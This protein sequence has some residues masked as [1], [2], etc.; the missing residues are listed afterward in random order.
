MMTG[1]AEGGALSTFYYPILTVAAGI[2]SWYYQSEASRPLRRWSSKSLWWN[3]HRAQSKWWKTFLNFSSEFFTSCLQQGRSRCSAPVAN[4]FVG[5]WST[6]ALSRPI[7]A[8]F[9]KS[10][11]FL[12]LARSHHFAGPPSWL[13]SQG[14]FWCPQERPWQSHR[15]EFCNLW[16]RRQEDRKF[17]L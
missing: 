2:R 10:L 12:D 8:R 4:G 13:R 9:L 5:W 16:S 1:R 6:F 17:D 14:T 3:I 7:S 15:S 11:S